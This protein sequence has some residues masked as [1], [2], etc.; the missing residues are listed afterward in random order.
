MRGI[1]CAT[2]IK[3]SVRLYM[4]VDA[5]RSKERGKE[6]TIA[7]IETD[8]TRAKEKGKEAIMAQGGMKL[9]G[10][11]NGDG[12]TRMQGRSKEEERRQGRARGAGRD[13]S[14]CHRWFGCQRS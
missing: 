4:E 5:T 14:Q 13:S 3:R 9:T 2:E 7:D 11:D 12:K 10:K 1:L 8:A 6:A